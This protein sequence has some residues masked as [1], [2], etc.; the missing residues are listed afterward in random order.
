MA[1]PRPKRVAQSVKRLPTMQGTQVRFLGW[2]DLLEKEM[3]THS[4]ILAWIMPWTE[5]S[6]GLV[7]GVARVG[8]D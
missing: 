1:Q 7:C 6:G 8:H 5:A 4:G 3:T 2:E